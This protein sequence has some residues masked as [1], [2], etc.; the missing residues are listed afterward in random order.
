MV[1]KTVEENI[2]TAI[3][4]IVIT[5]AGTGLEKGHFPETVAITE[6]GSTS[7][8]RS[9]SNSRASTNRDRIH[10]YKCMGYN[11]FARDCPT[12]KEEKEIEQL[13]WMLHL[14]DEQTITPT[15]SNMQN[16]FSRAGSE[17]N[18]RANHLNL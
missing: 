6:L 1:D 8:S 9:R 2:E 18:L 3:E 5:E 7:N 4:M 17:E 16:E 12:S 15:M 14:G 10:C 13:Q 11:H